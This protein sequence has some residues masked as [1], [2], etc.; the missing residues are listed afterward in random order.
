MVL[1]LFTYLNIFYQVDCCNFFLFMLVFFVC[2][3]KSELNPSSKCG[4]FFLARSKC[5]VFFF[6]HFSPLN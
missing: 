5:E 1:V 6:F 4:V 2:L 3:T